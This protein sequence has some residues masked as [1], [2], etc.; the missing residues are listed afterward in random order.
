[1]EVPLGREESEKV[2][3][4]VSKNGCSR[5]GTLNYKHERNR[6]KEK[7]TGDA[8]GNGS[9]VERNVYSIFGKVWAAF[10][11]YASSCFLLRNFSED[12]LLKIEMFSKIL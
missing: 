8:K 11:C 10:L 6:A 12:F 5:E 1:M 3:R 7:K 4:Q 9:Q 2:G